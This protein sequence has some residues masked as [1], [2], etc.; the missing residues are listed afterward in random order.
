MT[1]A[2][3]RKLAA[4]KAVTEQADAEF[5]ALVEVLGGPYLHLGEPWEPTTPERGELLREVLKR[6]R[7]AMNAAWENTR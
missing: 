7:P 4:R 5:M 1:N 6:Y 3:D 2:L